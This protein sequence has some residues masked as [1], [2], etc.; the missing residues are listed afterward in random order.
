MIL[1]DKS[2]ECKVDKVEMSP[3]SRILSLICTIHGV[4]MQLINVYAH[5][6]NHMNAARDELFEKD[7]MYYLRHNIPNTYMSEDWN[8]IINNRDVSRPGALQVSKSLT[9][10]IRDARFSIVWHINNRH[11]EY[12]Y[13][14]ENYGSG[15]DRI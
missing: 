5:S 11:I 7:L 13:V 4:K 2:F 15:I 6:G 1:I 14:R 10:L 8:C 3:D 12:T 9:K